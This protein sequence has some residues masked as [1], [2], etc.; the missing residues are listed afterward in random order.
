MR[1]V[2]LRSR[3]TIIG[4]KVMVE[5]ILEK[6]GGMKK[7]EYGMNEILNRYIYIL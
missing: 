7:I 4:K 5:G 1:L 6:Y 3:D 2:L